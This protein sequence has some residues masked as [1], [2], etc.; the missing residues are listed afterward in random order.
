MRGLVLVQCLCHHSK[1]FANCLGVQP[2]RIT[3]PKFQGGR[4]GV[5]QCLVDCFRA[6]PLVHHNELGQTFLDFCII[7]DHSNQGIG[8]PSDAFRDISS[9]HVALRKRPGRFGHVAM[10][11]V[12][13]QFNGTFINVHGQRLLGLWHFAVQVVG[14]FPHCV[15]LKCNTPLPITEKQRPLLGSTASRF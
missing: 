9:Q 4:H 11:Q 5:Q 12:L 1:N 2:C 8:R 14:P 13:I 10:L 15:C 3:S 6:T 7:T